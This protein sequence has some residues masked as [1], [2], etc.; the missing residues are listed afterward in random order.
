MASTTTAIRHLGT[1][2]RLCSKKAAANPLIMKL[3]TAAVQ[4]KK[5]IIGEAIPEFKKM[6]R[7]QNSPY[8]KYY[9]D[10]HTFE[11]IS[12]LLDDPAVKGKV[13]GNILLAALLHDIAK[14][15][16]ETIKEG[17]K[18]TYLKHDKV[19]AEMVKEILTH[20]GIIEGK[21]Q[22]IAL[23]ENHMAPVMIIEKVISGELSDKALGRFARNTVEPL[24]KAGIDLE[25]ILAF[26]RADLLASQGPDCYKAMGAAAD[27]YSSLESRVTSAV[28]QIK[29]KV[30]EYY[31]AQK[32]AKAGTPQS[33]TGKDL[34]K[35]GLKPGPNFKNILAEAAQLEREQGLSGE[36]LVKFLVEKHT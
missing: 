1:I 4:R 21:D 31:D 33:I 30:K 19:G 22:I 16:T 29:I 7:S 26:G 11:F 14:P 10:E 32:K 12:A 27:D 24:G 36:A 15:N 5:G 35:A 28:E 9:M 25:M 20:L 13:T 8:H 3:L 23:V 34:I 18:S 17:G 6:N 2:Q